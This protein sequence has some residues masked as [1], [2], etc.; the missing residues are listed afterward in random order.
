MSFVN[1][2]VERTRYLC[3]IFIQLLLVWGKSSYSQS[4]TTKRN[5]VFSDKSYNRT[6]Q[7]LPFGLC[8]GLI[9][10]ISFAF[11]VIRTHHSYHTLP[12]PLDAS[13]LRQILQWTLPP[14]GINSGSRKGKNNGNHENMPTE[15]D[16][17]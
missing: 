13:I 4:I 2:C 12:P 6:T 7:D 11:D 17:G 1:H 15:K 14:Q 3:Y 9:A 10:T 5:I 16:D 8:T